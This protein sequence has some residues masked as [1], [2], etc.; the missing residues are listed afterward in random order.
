MRVAAALATLALASSCSR[1]CAKEAAS[2]AGPPARLELAFPAKLEAPALAAL[3][4]TRGYGL[5]SGCELSGPIRRAALPGRT[6]FVASRRELGAL[7][8]AASRADAGSAAERAGAFELA[9]GK[10]T[11]L[12]WAEL[13]A[14]PLMDKAAGGWVAGW[15]LET[16]QDQ[17][18]ALLWRGGAEA[19]L[20]AE[21]Y[22]LSLADLACAG[23][24]CA[25]LS[26]LARNAPAPG[27]TLMLGA[28]TRPAS[29]FT[30]HDL[31]PGGEPSWK[32]L[33]LGDG[34]LVA[35]SSSERVALYRIADD[36]PGQPSFVEAPHGAYEA[37]A[38]PEPVVIA[39]GAP[40]DRPCGSE[41]FPIVIRG[42]GGKKFELRTP[43]PPESVIA[44]SLDRGALL[45]WIAPVSCALLT[46]R[47][48]YLTLLGPG[49]EPLSSPMAV[50]DAV[51][52]SLSTAGQRMHLWLS[53]GERLSLIDASCAAKQP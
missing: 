15:T 3:E 29:S 4:G 20:L 19:E 39:P 33:A 42:P 45:G 2:D 7:A 13:D 48:V 41:E 9:T 17:S 50:S 51:G 40:V 27:A 21:G 23:D 53:D 22:E 47:V 5:P 38:T 31:E 24:R 14:P 1:S 32:P 43:A 25:I 36:K 10:V 35:L 46:R 37:V 44:R 26:T 49:G 8:L 28:A 30:R 18:R 11:E 34:G 6:R 12:P 16:G 52:F